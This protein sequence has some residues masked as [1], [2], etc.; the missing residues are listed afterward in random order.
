LLLLPA[1]VIVVDDMRA[2]PGAALWAVGGLVVTIGGLILGGLPGGLI[3]AVLVA[4]AYAGWRQ[5]RPRAAAAS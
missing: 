1:F 4:A 2:R 3:A 5:V